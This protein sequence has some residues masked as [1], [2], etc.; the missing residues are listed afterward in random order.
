[1]W[2]IS[3]STCNTP[4]RHV[5]FTTFEYDYCEK[6]KIE[7]N[8]YGYPVH[9]IVYS[10]EEKHKILVEAGWKYDVDPYFHTTKYF[11]PITK[12]YYTLAEAFEE[13]KNPR[14]IT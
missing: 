11:H 5:V 13:H 4:I 10:E 2:G 14:E 8:A 1:M 6:C 12:N 7:T 9:Y 3:C